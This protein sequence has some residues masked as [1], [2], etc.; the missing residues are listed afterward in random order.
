MNVTGAAVDVIPQGVTDFTDKLDEALDVADSALNKIENSLPESFDPN[1]FVADT[2]IDVK[3]GIADV[4]KNDDGSVTVYDKNGGSQTIPAGTTAAIKDD[5]GNGYL[6]DK[7]GNI[8]KTTADV[9]AK[10]GNREYNLMLRF[11][12]NAQVRYGFDEQKYDAITGYEK[13]DGYKVPWKA[14][15]SGGSDVVT[16]AL[17]GAAD[18]DTRKIHFE[19]GGATLSASPALGKT[20]PAG[21]TLTGKSDGLEEGLLAVYA[22]GDTGKVQVLGKLNVVTYDEI[23]HTVVIVPVNGAKYPY[24]ISVLR[25]SLNRIYGQAVVKWSVETVDPITVTLPDTFN[26][27]GTGVFSNYTDDMKTV[28]NAYVDNMDDDK[29]YLFLIGGKVFGCCIGLY[30]P[31]QAGRVY[32]RRS[33]GNRKT[34]HPYSSARAWSWCLQPAPHI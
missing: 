31:Q 27:G 34:N 24:S 17:T 16:A 30:A 13:I 6:V 25:D 14:V 10:A 23:Q 4:R 29:F 11:A 22:P 15:T 19:Q 7:K 9:A 28:I 21:V 1:S 18:L 5:N 26:D 3:N 8:H 20:Q 32:F 2:L 12:A 33:D